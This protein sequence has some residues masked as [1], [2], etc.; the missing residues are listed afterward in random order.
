M[1]GVL[2]FEHYVGQLHYD[3]SQCVDSYLYEF[4]C[5]LLHVCVRIIAFVRVC[6]V[7]VCF[8]YFLFSHT[9][10]WPCPI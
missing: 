7:G 5:A 9:Q 8:K 3:N 10:L 6:P 4:R 2:A 1:T